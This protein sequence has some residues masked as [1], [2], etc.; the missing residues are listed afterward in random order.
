MR[1]MTGFYL[2]TLSLWA[3]L[4][5]SADNDVPVPNALACCGGAGICRVPTDVPSALE[6]QLDRDAC[7]EAQLCVPKGLAFA[8]L[9][10]PAACRAPGDREGRCLSLCLPALADQADMLDQRGCNSDERCMPCFDPITGADTEA[11]QIGDDAPGEQ[12]RVYQ[13]CCGAIGEE[14]G[15]CV[16]SELLSAKQL[17]TLPVDS[18]RE[19]GTRCVLRDPEDSPGAR[20]LSSL[21][22][23]TLPQQ[24]DRGAESQ[25]EAR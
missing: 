3:C 16:P 4:P 10:P 20:N 25:R 8:L 2:V 9:N 12:A 6:S 14:R 7:A 23:C 1:T 19:P 15:T 22:P 17:D 18:C 11:C 21:D 13:R 5:E 24:P